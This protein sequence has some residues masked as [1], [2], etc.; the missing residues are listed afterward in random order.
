VFLPASTKGSCP[1]ARR[2]REEIATV[3][4]HTAC[5]SRCALHGTRRRG[6]ASVTVMT[7]GRRDRSAI[8]ADAPYKPHT[9]RPTRPAP[10]DAESCATE[11]GHRALP[12][13]IWLACYLWRP[14]L[15]A[16]PCSSRWAC[17]HAT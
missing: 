12:P 8:P 2:G 3:R 14:D 10:T 1:V 15:L 13:V 17:A 9:G 6:H 11:R 16:R 7:T 4:E 5:G